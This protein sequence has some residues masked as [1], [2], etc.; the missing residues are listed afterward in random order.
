MGY[1]FPRQP[2]FGALALMPA[3]CVCLSFPLAWLRR[4]NRS[5]WP[6]ALLH[7][8]INTMSSAAVTF[9]AAD[10]VPISLAALWLVV[11]VPFAVALDRGARRAAVPAAA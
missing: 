1:N 6:C 10:G 8:A 5:I 4:G 11:A 2:I 9:V 7:G 3:F